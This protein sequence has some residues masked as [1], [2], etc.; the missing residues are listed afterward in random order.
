[1]PAISPNPE[2]ARNRMNEWLS[3]AIRKYVDNKQGIIVAVVVSHPDG[4]SVLSGPQSNRDYLVNRLQKAIFTVSRG[5]R[6]HV[7]QCISYEVRA[8]QGIIVPG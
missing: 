3:G 2:E 1:M 4:L 8:E 6:R 5:E 7:G